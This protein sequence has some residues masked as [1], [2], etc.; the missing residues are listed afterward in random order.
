[1]GCHRLGKPKAESPKV[2]GGSLEVG[3]IEISM[4]MY[5]L[6]VVCIVN[7]YN[8]HRNVY[9][10]HFCA[11]VCGFAWNVYSIHADFTPIQTC[12]ILVYFYIHAVFIHCFLK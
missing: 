12:I 5:D 11:S 8:I 1:M 10:N 6:R 2:S 4:S 9:L 7:V 3:D